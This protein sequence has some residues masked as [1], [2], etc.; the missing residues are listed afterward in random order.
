MIQLRDISRSKLI[1]MY[2]GDDKKSN[3]QNW[4]ITSSAILMS[5]LQNVSYFLHEHVSPIIINEKVCNWVLIQDKFGTDPIIE[6]GRY[7]Y[8]RRW[9]GWMTNYHCIAEELSNVVHTGKIKE[10][11][12]LHWQRDWADHFSTESLEIIFTVWRDTEYQCI[13]DGHDRTRSVNVTDTLKNSSKSWR[14]IVGSKVSK[15]C[16]YERG[17]VPAH[18]V[19]LKVYE[20]EVQ[21]KSLLLEQRRC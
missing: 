12:Q 14:R 5:Q 15:T 18:V 6:S 4:L 1:F 19:Y 17:W 13:R 3:H 20:S 21:T 8:V 10:W 7:V 11:A 2:P 9:S 16:Q